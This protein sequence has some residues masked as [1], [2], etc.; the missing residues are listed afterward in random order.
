MRGDGACWIST[1][2][3]EGEESTGIG[4]SG[5]GGGGGGVATFWRFVL[6]LV[7]LAPFLFGW[8][9]WGASTPWRLAFADALVCCSNK[10]EFMNTN[11]ADVKVIG[12]SK[13]GLT[14]CLESLSQSGSSY[15]L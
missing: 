9:D 11:V 6:A 12:I 2:G 8:L 7:P 4:D 13:K 14:N 10:K 15:R 1:S 5:G 3:G